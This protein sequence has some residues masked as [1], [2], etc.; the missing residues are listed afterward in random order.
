MARRTIYA[1][2]PTGKQVDEKRAASVTISFS[3]AR[4]GTIVLAV[5][6]TEISD[7]ISKGIRERRRGRKPNASAEATGRRLTAKLRLR[8]P[9]P[10]YH[11]QLSSAFVFR[12]AISARW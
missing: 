6:E 3:D 12:A 1:S 5:N 11:P 4:R 2:D 8:R 7:L 9:A 10:A